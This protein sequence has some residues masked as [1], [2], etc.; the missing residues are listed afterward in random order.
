MT[1]E[2]SDFN[3]FHATR[4]DP[5]FQAEWELFTLL[6]A[7]DRWLGDVRGEGLALLQTD[8]TAALF[9]AARSAGRTAPMN[10]LA[11]EIA[12]RLECASVVVEHEHL[13]ATLNFHCD[14]LSRLSEGHE[15]PAAVRHIEPDS[16][17]A[18]GPEF[19]WAWTSELWDPPA[20]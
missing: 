2:E 14:A 19:W 4:G 20:A 13:E 8:A 18:R 16:L 5:A 1:W 10:A 6:L 11:V 15:V 7:V 9:A 12:L 17:P 3:L